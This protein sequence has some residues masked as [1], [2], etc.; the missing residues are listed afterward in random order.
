MTFMVIE[1]IHDFRVESGIFQENRES[2]TADALAP[3]SV[4]ANNS[5]GTS[6]I[7]DDVIKWKHLY[8]W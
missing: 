8:L 3:L 4:Q 5:H 1:V 6:Y 2:I 7:H